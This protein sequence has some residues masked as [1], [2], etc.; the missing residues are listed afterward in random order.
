MVIMNDLHSPITILKMCILSIQ[1]CISVNPKFG[2]RP[3]S[4]GRTIISSA[5]YSVSGA[6]SFVKPRVDNVSNFWCLGV[7]RVPNFNTKCKMSIIDALKFLLL[8]RHFSSPLNHQI[9]SIV[10]KL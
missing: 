9:K 3:C 2:H 10:L 8:F 4:Y 5:S 1:A 6:N 7:G